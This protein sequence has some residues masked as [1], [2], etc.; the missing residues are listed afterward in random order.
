MPLGSRAIMSE[1]WND[2][3]LR[4]A[5]VA[6]HDM[7]T[8]QA[9]G[10]PVNKRR[11]YEE[12]SRRYGRTA[13]SFEY[14]M[15][16]ISHVYALQ[17]RTWVSGLRPARNVGA[18]VIARL[19]RIIADVE[20]Q[21]LGDIAGYQA[22]VAYL[23]DNQPDEPPVGSV[24]P[25]ATTVEVTQ[26]SRD[27][28]VAAWVLNAANG[29]CEMCDSPA[30]FEREDGT[31]FLEVHH[32]IRLADQGVDTIHN[33]VALCPNCHRRLHYG[34][35]KL[36]LAKELAKKIPRLRLNLATAGCEN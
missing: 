1:Q 12:L 11:Y 4:A 28:A 29:R 7:R 34:R 13:K 23:Q 15:Q 3:E 31:P 20:G 2:Q 32:V 10:L 8:R 17:G 21:V 5:V 22:R 6:Y 9:R 18:N 33:T 24:S 26:Y 35:D 16:N 19:E 25:Q 27:P 36:R 14:R 30:P